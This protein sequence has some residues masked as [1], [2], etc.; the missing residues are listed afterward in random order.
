[1]RRL[2]LDAARHKQKKSRRRLRLGAHGLVVVAL[3]RYKRRL[4]GMIMMISEVHMLVYG[5][6][7]FW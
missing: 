1:M 6:I 4:T 5:I 3:Q 7:F 2:W